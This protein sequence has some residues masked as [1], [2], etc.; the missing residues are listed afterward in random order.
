MHILDFQ[1]FFVGFILLSKL[2]KIYQFFSMTRLFLYIK[3]A[4]F[5]VKRKQYG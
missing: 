4:N 5:D 1:E 3:R 2:V